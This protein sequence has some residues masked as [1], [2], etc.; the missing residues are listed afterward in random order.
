LATLNLKTFSRKSPAS[1]DSPLLFAICAL[2]SWGNN[3]WMRGI[4]EEKNNLMVEEQASST[5]GRMVFRDR[6]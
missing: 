6:T 2:Q 4:F 3:R 1:T 5:I